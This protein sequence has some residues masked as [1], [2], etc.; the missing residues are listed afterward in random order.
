MA[1]VNTSSSAPGAA[2]G[3]QTAFFKFLSRY[4]PYFRDPRHVLIFK[5]D[6]ILLTW[7]FLAGVSL[8]PMENKMV[9]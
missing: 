8:H 6:C 7:T 2:G 4:I 5:L 3:Q 9:L 1:N